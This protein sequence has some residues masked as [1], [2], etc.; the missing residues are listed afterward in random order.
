MRVRPPSSAPGSVLALTCLG[1][2]VGRAAPS[3]GV[4]A[5]GSNPARGTKLEEVVTLGHTAVRMDCTP[6]ELCYLL[7]S[8]KVCPKCGG[9]LEKSKEHE[10]R[11]GGE[12]KD[13]ARGYFIGTNEK[14]KYYFCVFTCAECGSKYRLSELVK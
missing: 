14:V 1:S 11:Q 3:Y 2:S 9:K 5:A 8:K 10:I 13:S 6:K 4:A 7:F 12:F